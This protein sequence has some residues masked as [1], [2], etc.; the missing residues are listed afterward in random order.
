[1]VDPKFT[2]LTS[3]AKFQKLAMLKEYQ[4]IVLNEEER[5]SRAQSLDE[6]ISKAMSEDSARLSELTLNQAK[7]MLELTKV[8]E[9][10]QKENFIWAYIAYNRLSERS[11]LTLKKFIDELHTNPNKGLKRPSL[12]NAFD[13]LAFNYCQV[14]L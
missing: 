2:S 14:C 4:E 7:Y 1:M 9:E 10:S 11:F 12:K 3:T 8:K 13:E 6:E 5:K